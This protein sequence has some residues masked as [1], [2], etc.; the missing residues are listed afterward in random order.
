MAY[1]TKTAAYCPICGHLYDVT[2]RGPLADQQMQL[3]KAH[4]TP[5]PKCQEKQKQESP[6]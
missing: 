6:K 5:C 1:V 2:L 3:A 4:H